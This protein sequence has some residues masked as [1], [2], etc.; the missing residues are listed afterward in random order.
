MEARLDRGRWGPGNPPVG[1]V[2]IRIQCR[3]TGRISVQIVL[4]EAKHTAHQLLVRM[5]A[6]EVKK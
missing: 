6:A 2:E 3:E 1:E 4:L 5:Q